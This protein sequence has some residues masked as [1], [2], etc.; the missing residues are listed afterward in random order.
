[1]KQILAISLVLLAIACQESPKKETTAVAIK[2]TDSLLISG[3]IKGY[4][5]GDVMISWNDGDR[6]FSDTMKGEKGSFQDRFYFPSARTIYLVAGEKRASAFVQPGELKLTASLDAFRKPSLEG[7]AVLPDYETYQKITQALT[8]SLEMAGDS[9]DASNSS[10]AAIKRTALRAAYSNAYD[11]KAAADSVY[12]ST[13]PSS[14]VAAQLLLDKHSYDPKL[15]VLEADYNRLTD[16]V[17]SSFYGTRLAKV[18]E[19]ARKTDIGQP[20][21]DFTLTDTKGEPVSLA[22][23]KGKYVLVDFW[24]S[25]CGPCRQENPAVVKAYTKYHKKGFDVLGVSLDEDRDKWIAAIAKD[26]L[27]WTQVSDLKGWQSDVARLYGING[28]PYNFLV[29]KEGKIIAKGLRGEDLAAKI[30]ALLP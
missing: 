16:T 19:I 27:T 5:S 23:Y 20:A 12:V 30:E 24:A 2:A 11:K 18:L 10:T 8:D 3:L 13:H 26:K 14:L 28:I 25:W 6:F 29:D 4:D 9:L 7:T 15:A 22:A 1:M 17:K 21:M